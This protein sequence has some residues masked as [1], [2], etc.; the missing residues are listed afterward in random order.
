MKLQLL[1]LLAVTSACGPA[2]STSGEATDPIEDGGTVT[3][4]SSGMM[5]DS[6]SAPLDGSSAG[7]SM[8]SGSPTETT[9][10]TG[11]P[12]PMKQFDGSPADVDAA[13]VDAG[14][15]CTPIPTL[16]MCSGTAQSVGGSTF[17]NRDVRTGTC[18]ATATPA[19]CR[20]LE[21]YTCDCIF[22]SPGNH[23]C[24]SAFGETGASCTMQSNGVPLVSC[25]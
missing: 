8:D 18:T 19:A 6:T 21:T 20:C 14:P 24:L 15:T 2:F 11:S 3:A 9:T 4:T 10:D 13:T 1:C 25:Q 7:S 22:N 12:G 17:D 16:A 5:P 23:S